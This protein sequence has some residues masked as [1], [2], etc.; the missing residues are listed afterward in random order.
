MYKMLTDFTFLLQLKWIS[1]LYHVQ[2]IHWWLGGEWGHSPL[3]NAPTNSN[4]SII[5]YINVNETDFAALSKIVRDE[6]WQESMKFYT[7]FWHVI[8]FVFPLN[9]T[10]HLLDKKVSRLL[11]VRFGTFT[12]FNRYQAYHTRMQFAVLITMLTQGSR[13]Y[14]WWKCVSEEVQEVIQTMRC[15]AC[16]WEVYMITY[17]SR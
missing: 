8:A 5:T 13:Q 11:V 4:G 17:Q 3:T 2:D 16:Y 10:W 15:D 14:W 9:N 6:S 1:L 12:T 7:K